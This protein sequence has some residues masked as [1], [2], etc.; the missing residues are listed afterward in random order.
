MI[1]F[2][3]LLRFKH[4]RYSANQITTTMAK[5]L[6][7]VTLVMLYFNP[8]SSMGFIKLE[9]GVHVKTLAENCQM[10][11]FKIGPK[12]AIMLESANFN[13]EYASKLSCKETWQY[14]EIIFPQIFYDQ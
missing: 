14:F 10:E 6:T 9:P 11:K 2:C 4:N 8:V 12:S 13:T 3:T 7:I 5:K 1:R